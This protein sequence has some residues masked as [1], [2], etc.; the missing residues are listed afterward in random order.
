MNAYHEKISK[1]AQ[2]QGVYKE[3]DFILNFGDC[4]DGGRKC[5]EEMGP[6]FT[7]AAETDARS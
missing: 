3:S 2:P 1:S 5:A 4:D 6:Y 7:K